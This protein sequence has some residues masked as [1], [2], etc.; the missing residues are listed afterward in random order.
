MRCFAWTVRPLR[1]GVTAKKG[2]KAAVEGPAG[3]GL[4]SNEVNSGT[5]EGRN[6]ICKAYVKSEGCTKNA[7]PEKKK[8]RRLAAF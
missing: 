5:P 8:I 7:P 4:R 6:K 3:G 1:K 2:M